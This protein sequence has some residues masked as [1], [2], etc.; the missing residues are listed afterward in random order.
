MKFKTFLLQ[1]EK[2]ETGAEQIETRM[3]EL[4]VVP[5]VVLEREENAAP[6]AKALIHGGLPC[7][8]LLFGRLQRK[9]RSA[10]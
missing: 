7:A 9:A 6:L 10:L 2:N 5:V 3:E 1:E 4:G 8:K